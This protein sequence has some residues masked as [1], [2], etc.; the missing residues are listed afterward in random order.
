MMSAEVRARPVESEPDQVPAGCASPAVVAGASNG[1]DP[2]ARAFY[3]RMLEELRGSGV[4]FLLGGAYAFARYTGIERHTKDIDVFVRPADADRLLAVLGGAGCAIELTHPHWLGKAHCG[5][6]F[7]DVIYS[8][9]NGVARVDDD[10]FAHAVPDHVLDVPV[11]LIP[12][13]EMLWSKAFV[14]ERER[15]DG[16]DVAHLLRATAEDLNW[17]RLLDRFDENWRVLLVHLTL[18]G[19]VYPG[20]R[21][22]VPARALRELTERLDAELDAPD[23]D[24]TL[25]RGTLIS[26]E[27]YLPDVQRWGYRDARLREEG[28]AM[29]GRQV[30][31]WT[32]AIARDGSGSA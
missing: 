19:F 11:L 27:Q 16:A 32:A 15:F 28:G 3:I 17:R 21:H 18:F 20:E 24:A 8:S 25:F 7:V 9:G 26:R 13:E 2:V 5:G 14:M 29:S 1:L 30:A 4:P 6:D 22:R 23:A 10:W 31:A 12:P